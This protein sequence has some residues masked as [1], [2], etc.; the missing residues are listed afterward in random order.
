MNM[1]VL[2]AIKRHFPVLR[3]VKHYVRSVT[4]KLSNDHLFLGRRCVVAE[5]TF[6][7]YVRAGNEVILSSSHIDSY[8]YVGDGCVINRTTI[9]K[10]CSIATGVQLGS[11]SHPTD[12]FV[13]SHPIFYLYRPVFGWDYVVSDHAPEYAPTVVGNDVW[14]GTRA[15]IRD[16]VRIGDG[17]VIGA[18][19]L[20]LNDLEPFGIYVGIPAKLVRF[21]FEPAQVAFLKHCQWWNRDEAWI[22]KNAAK[23]RGVNDL[24][25]DSDQ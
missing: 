23:F 2:I 4:L 15:T 7:R 6:G 3:S 9:G 20:V 24:M 19:A 21:R 5:T 22:R 25:R 17:V 1:T 10:Y 12:T 18:G 16:G 14:I 8:T 13:S 11:G